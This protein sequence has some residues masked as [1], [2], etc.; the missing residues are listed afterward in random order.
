MPNS[1]SWNEYNGLP[2]PRRYWAVLAMACA[3]TASVIDASMVSVALPTISRDLNVEPSF[4]IWIV[5]AYQVAIMISL[6]PLAALGDIVGYSRVYLGGLVVFTIA[7]LTSSLADSLPTLMFARVLQGFGAAGLM[8]VNM[9][10]V[11]F[12]YP[13]E[14][15]GRGIGFNAVVLAVAAAAGPTVASAILAVAHWRWIFAVSVPIGLISFGI[16]MWAFPD[17]PRHRRRF[18]FLSAG[19][20]AL[21]FGLLILLVDSVSRGAPAWLLSAEI[22]A[23]LI[24]G[25]LLLRRQ[26]AATAPLL[27]VD[28]LR[29]PIFALSIGTSICSFVAQTLAIVSLPF[30]MQTNLGRTA[31]QTGLLMTP[32][33]LATSVMA[34]IAGRLSDKHSAGLLGLLGLA[35]FG[36]GLMALALLPAHAGTLDVVW[37]MALTGAG[38]G[39]YQSPNN[40]AMITSAP[41]ERSGGAAGMQGMARLIGQSFGAAF[42]ATLFGVLRQ[43]VATV[44]ALWVGG[45]FAALGAVVSALR[46]RDFVQTPR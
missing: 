28:L 7:S 41:R 42:A 11:R 32:W 12:T 36:A 43:D 16:G 1:S 35:M 10:L 13:V 31:V 4:A 33:P 24:F 17:S 22:G 9:A 37:R 27:P 38:F 25:A 26:V 14:N 39:L 40:R 18:D 30:F 34:P 3:L 45:G 23:A 21:T 46:L 19:L 2:L 29:I 5:N 20:S 8:S 15:L 44:T 6:L